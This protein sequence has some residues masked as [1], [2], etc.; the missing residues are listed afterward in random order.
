VS[1][2]VA[3]STYGSYPF[4]SYYAKETGG[5][6]EEAP[7]SVSVSQYN[8]E[9]W[10]DTPWAKFNVTGPVGTQVE[11]ISSYGTHAQT[12]SS[13]NEYV[14]LW[15]SSLPPA[16]VEFPIT[17]KINGDVFGTYAFTSHFDPAGVSV[18]VSQYNTESSDQNPW[19]KFN[20][21]GPV[22]T[23]VDILSPY[24]NASQTLSSTNE[25]VK[26][27]F[28]SLPPAGEP[29]TLTVK[30]DGGVWG[31]YGFTSWYSEPAPVAKTANATYGTCAEDPP[32]DVYFG[33]APEGTSISITSAYGSGSTTA[34]GSGEWSKQVFFSGAPLDEPFTVN[35]QAGGAS[36]DFQM[37]VTASG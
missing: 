24:G 30:I 17:V 28:S 9:S 27:W 37:V 21:T 18:S 4:T 5:G 6:G 33:T 31:S 13:I 34:N 16:G 19:A 7:A 11:L 29:F 23:V 25:H 12:T 20:V 10:D 8:T 32:Y 14:K 36:F 26:L 15:F 3:G 1:V 22:G 35:V 2:K